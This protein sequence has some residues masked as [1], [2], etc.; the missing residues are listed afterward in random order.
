M[1]LT[2]KSLLGC[3]GKSLVLESYVAPSVHALARVLRKHPDP[4]G[5]VSKALQNVPIPSATRTQIQSAMRRLSGAS[6]LAFDN[7]MPLDVATAAER[8][9]TDTERN[10]P[11]Q[12]TTN[13]LSFMRTAKSCGMESP[14]ALSSVSDDDNPVRDPTRR[15]AVESSLMTLGEAAIVSPET[16]KTRTGS[17]ATKRMSAAV[18]DSEASVVDI[19]DEELGVDE[20]L[21]I[22]SEAIE[23][24]LAIA[25][26][27]RATRFNVYRLHSAATVFGHGLADRIRCEIMDALHGQH[28]RLQA[29]HICR[30]YVS[31]TKDAYSWIRI[32]MGRCTMKPHQCNVVQV[33]VKESEAFVAM[34]IRRLARKFTPVVLTAL[35]G[36]LVSRA[37]VVKARQSPRTRDSVSSLC[38]NDPKSL[39][40]SASSM[41]SLRAAGRFVHAAAPSNPLMELQKTATCNLLARHDDIAGQPQLHLRSRVV[42]KAAPMKT[43][44]K[45]ASIIDH[46]ASRHAA[47][48]RTRD[49][50]FGRTPPVRSCVKWDMLEK[51]SL[52]DDSVF[53]PNRK[54]VRY[55]IKGPNVFEG[56]KALIDAGLMEVDEPLPDYIRDATH[57]GSIIKVLNGAIVKGDKVG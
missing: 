17:Q 19:H 56:M 26:R 14:L 48:K 49:F 20:F 41:D 47:A 30:V 31:T 13:R 25:G 33:V 12:Q 11:R 36:A 21:F 54:R 53:A 50:V 18:S 46:D 37:V 39:L 1:V 22:L 16:T 57:L 10:N 40:E 32:V 43:T 52:Y 23:L 9:F 51:R 27:S 7:N 6:V 5:A 45:A 29:N 3:K 34:S 42:S 55:T 2:P 35:E 28:S 15:G 44:A 38:G 4:A 8:S 24:Q